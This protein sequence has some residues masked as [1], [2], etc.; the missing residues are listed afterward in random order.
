MYRPDSPKCLCIG[1]RLNVSIDKNAVVLPFPLHSFLL[2]F[3][4]MV[5]SSYSLLHIYARTLARTQSLNL[6]DFGCAIEISSVSFVGGVVLNYMPHFILIWW[7]SSLSLHRIQ[8][9]SG[10]GS[11]SMN[12]EFFKTRFNG[13]CELAFDAATFLRYP[14][15]FRIWIQVRCT[16]AL[17]NTITHS[18]THTR[19]C[20][21]HR[22]NQAIK[23]IYI[24][25]C[26]NDI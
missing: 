26:F 21:H 17:V 2:L 9:H 7:C 14:I 19:T 25:Y 24:W 15:S 8:W 5:F 10:N 3:L 18:H 1:M 22:C 11:V 13:G 12:N 16:H 4:S 6:L 20:W 23:C